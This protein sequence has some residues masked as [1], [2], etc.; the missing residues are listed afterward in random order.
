MNAQAQNK[1]ALQVK[2]H[3]GPYVVT[4]VFPGQPNPQAQRNIT[5][6]IM[7]AYRERKSKG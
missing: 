1:N 6:Q 4:L 7:G 5:T 3:V 2:M